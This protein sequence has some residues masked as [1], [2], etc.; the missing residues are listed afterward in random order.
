[1]RVSIAPDRTGYTDL[2][3]EH[4]IAPEL[5]TL[6]GA[7]MMISNFPIENLN[8]NTLQGHIQSRA[9]FVQIKI[10]EDCFN[11]DGIRNFCARV[12]KCGIP[13][14]QAI[15]LR[16]GEQWRDEEN[17]VRIKHRNKY[18]YNNPDYN[19]YQRSLMVANLRG[20]TIYPTCLQSM[21]E[22][23]E[24]IE[25]YQAIIRKVIS[26]D[27]RDLYP[28][29]PTPQFEPDNI[30]QN[31]IEVNE[32]DW[33]YFLCAGLK[34]F[35]PTTANNVMNYIHDNLPYLN[36]TGYYALKVLTDENEK[37]E[38]VHNIKGW[39]KKS[40]EKLRLLLQ[41]PPGYNLAVSSESDH[42]FRAGWKGFGKMFMEEV[43]SG[44][45][46]KIVFNRLMKMEIF[47]EKDSD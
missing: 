5:E 39:G 17:K 29:R 34:G 1:L 33:R 36:G 41:L 25:D 31:L 46:A 24:W 20:I 10:N 38:A 15:L 21:D 19:A 8:K 2:P 3:V 47:N 23:L 27:K 18:N 37:R 35:G 16:V 14:S 22:L 40:R 28:I 45:D 32:D 26:E 7:D 42:D 13:Q 43:S 6:T 30:W 4:I 11:F 9:L 44:E 12:Q